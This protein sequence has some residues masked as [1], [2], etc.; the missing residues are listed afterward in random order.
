MKVERIA[1]VIAVSLLL[2]GIFST[3]YVESSKEKI[4]PDYLKINGN[5]F[6]IKEILKSCSEKEIKPEAGGAYTGISLADMINFSGV[7]NPSEYKYKIVG[8]DGYS[9]TVDWN[10]LQNGIFYVEEKKVIFSDLPKQF[11][12]RD[13]VE[14]K[15]I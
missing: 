9:K 7:K 13:V 8:S 3:V 1:P 12:V 15:V 6:E 10:A 14:I 11:W 5:R 2:L 4:S